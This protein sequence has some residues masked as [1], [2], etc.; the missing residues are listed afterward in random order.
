MVVVLE[1]K[2]VEVLVSRMR[3]EKKLTKSKSHT[4]SGLN[5]TEYLEDEK[6]VH[7]SCRS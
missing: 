7:P 4:K 1:L 6:D 3:Q 5:Y 2:V